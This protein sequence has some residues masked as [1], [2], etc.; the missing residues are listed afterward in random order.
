MKTCKSCIHYYCNY[1]DVVN[2]VHKCTREL[3]MVQNPVT[4]DYTGKS[5]GKNC[6]EERSRIVIFNFKERCGINGRFWKPIE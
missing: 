3:N 6:E 1:G 2:G 5:S 4:G